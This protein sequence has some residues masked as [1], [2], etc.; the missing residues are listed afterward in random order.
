MSAALVGQIPSLPATPAIFIGGQGGGPAQPHRPS[1]R[2]LAPSAFR[3]CCVA[4]GGA[5]DKAAAFAPLPLPLLPHLQS[6]RACESGG[7]M[8]FDREPTAAPGSRPLQTCW[9][10]H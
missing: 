8:R 7:G 2:V 1:A 4:P 3:Y 6:R 9:E 5:G 10:P